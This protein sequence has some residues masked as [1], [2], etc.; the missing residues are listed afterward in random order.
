[1]QDNNSSVTLRDGEETVALP[2]ADDAGLIFIGRIRTPW[3]DRE[4][5]PRN[6]RESEALCTV[7]LDPRF[8]KGLAGLDTCS[9]IILLYWLHLAR[10]DLILQR[11][12]FSNTVIGTF[13]L[14]SPMRPNPI[15]LAVAE[16]VNVE[17]TRLTVRHVDC[18]DGTPLIDIKPYFA[19]VDAVPEAS[20]GW[21]SGR[22]K[23][24]P[25]RG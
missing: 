10:R 13:A 2:P 21:H 24:L 22:D 9:H 15:G 23:P 12:R 18:L 8:A 5:A 17:G 4:Q 6:P 1:M 14:R 19:S 25:A 7:E 11:P 20:V 3:T 16:L